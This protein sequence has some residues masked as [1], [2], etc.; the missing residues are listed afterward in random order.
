MSRRVAAKWGAVDHYG[1]ASPGKLWSHRV[2]W[3]GSTRTMTGDRLIIV[4][5]YGQLTPEEIKSH[6][7]TVVW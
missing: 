4:M 3:G 7:P 5:T 1:I 2:K 6:C